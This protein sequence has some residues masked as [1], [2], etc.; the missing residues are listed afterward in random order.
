[1]Q[2]D[3][4][5]TTLDP[6]GGQA[7]ALLSQCIAAST[8]DLDVPSVVEVTRAHGPAANAAGAVSIR[9]WAVGPRRWR[10]SMTAMLVGS[11]GKWV[12][13]QGRRTG[14]AGRRT[15]DAKMQQ[16]FIGVL[17]SEGWHHVFGQRGTGSFNT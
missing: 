14:A 9:A 12:G 8:L 2:L 17:K 3:S 7:G 4:T 5:A 6:D 15:V 13:H 11:S 1:M 10:R 16:C